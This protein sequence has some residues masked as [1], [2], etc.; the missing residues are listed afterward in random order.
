MKKTRPPLGMQPPRYHFLLKPQS[1]HRFT[2]CL[3]DGGLTRV[4]KFA[5]LIHLK[6]TG[7]VA[8]GRICR[9]CEKCEIIIADRLESE[10]LRA[11][12]FEQVDP[13]AIGSDDLLLR[14]VERAAWRSG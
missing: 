6:K 4:P 3:Q 7:M 13:R 11:D 9:S 2:R 10:D 5:L 12:L 8:P 1:E 14:M